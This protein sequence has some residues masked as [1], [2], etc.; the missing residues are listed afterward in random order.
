MLSSARVTHQNVIN[1]FLPT[2]CGRETTTSPLASLAT[3]RLHLTRH[4]TPWGPC[5]CST[6][7]C[8]H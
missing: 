8:L 5:A 4:A 2:Q 7:R 3:S 1:P 6:A